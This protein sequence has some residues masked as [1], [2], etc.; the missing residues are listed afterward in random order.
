MAIYQGTPQIVTRNYFNGPW[1][2]AG[3]IPGNAVA[4]HTMAASFT[5]V[6]GQKVW[7]YG[8]IATGPLD[9]RISAP[10][11]AVCTVGA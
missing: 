11:Y 6:Q 8:R 7:V 10:F 9:A 2:F 5:L 1:R 4:P 3:S